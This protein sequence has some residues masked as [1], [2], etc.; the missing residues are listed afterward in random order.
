M[1][2][3]HP[4]LEFGRKGFLHSGSKERQIFLSMVLFF[5]LAT[6]VGCAVPAD[7][8][9]QLL[10]LDLDQR[11]ST[12]KSLEAKQA[13]QPLAW[14]AYSLG[15]LYGAD[16]E[17]EQMNNWFKKSRRLSDELNTDI[18][19]IRLGHWKDEALKADS[20]AEAGN[21]VQAA[22]HLELA[23]A[24]APEQKETHWRWV[25]ARI[26]AYGPGLEEIRTLAMAQRPEVVYRWLE[27]NSGPGQS[28]ERLESRV[29][30]ASQLNNNNTET[31]DDL[32]A[33]TT[34][35]LCR[36][37][38][39]WVGMD[40]YYRLAGVNWR[41]PTNDARSEV[42]NGLLQ[43]SLVLWSTDQVALSLAKLD[44]ADVVDPDRA[45][46]FQARRNIVALNRAKKG[47]EVAEIL[48]TGDLDH[49]W[50]TF[51]MSRLYTRGRLRDAGMVA[52]ELLNQRD[53][54]ST[55]EKSQALRV[56]LA[57]LRSIGNLEQTRDDLRDLLATGAK[58]PT[59]AV[60]LGDVLLAQ[61]HYEEALHWFN[62]AQ[63][64]GDT[65]VSLLLKKARVAFS[66]DRFE[67]ME[68][69]AARAVEREPD[70]LEARQL[71]DR[72]RSLLPQKNGE[73]AQ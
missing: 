72:S 5:V 53:I 44:T 63:V 55:Y 50:Q 41:M 7:R 22:K 36:L 23:L 8:T 52:N 4:G 17:Y 18:E 47:S 25:E 20:E 70:N 10:E 1:T 29:R 15:V 54:L 21:W 57:F 13:V 56:R 45:D 38:G 11:E 65:S 32:A 34:G 48:A 43:Q 69:L 26:M 60:I 28:T 62:K 42:A 39:D 33:Y 9:K 35:E 66:Q 2:A 61:S 58:L 64:W 6:C 19:H 40:Q 30:L 71:W 51:W 3:F 59:E 12:I 49:R 68:I 16:G 24:A 14:Q 31:G 27:Q 73:V 37:D 46:V 67:D